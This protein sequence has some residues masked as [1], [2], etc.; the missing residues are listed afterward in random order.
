[1]NTQAAPYRRVLTGLASILSEFY[2]AILERNKAGEIF[3]TLPDL[4]GVN[5]AGAT[6]GEALAFA[7]EFANDYVRDLVADGHEVPPARAIDAIEADTD[8]T[9]LARVLIPVEVPGRSVKISLSIDEAL[10]KRVDRA[11]G[12]IGMTRSGFFATA[13]Q[14]KIRQAVAPRAGYGF[15]GEPDAVRG[16]RESVPAFAGVRVQYDPNHIVVGDRIMA[17]AGDASPVT[18]ATSRGK[19]DGRPPRPRRR[20]RTGSGRKGK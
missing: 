11:A 1:M 19:N 6:A 7:V 18:T 12:T 2:V 4:P 10:L 20:R 3:A 14:E 8:V 9:E 5:A 13:V 16:F 17:F 15:A